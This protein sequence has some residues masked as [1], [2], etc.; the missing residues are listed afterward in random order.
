M[1]HSMYFCIICVVF[2][3]LFF[4]LLVLCAH[5]KQSHT[6]FN[7]VYIYSSI[8]VSGTVISHGYC[9][10]ILASPGHFDQIRPFWF[11]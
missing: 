5:I 8:Y 1:P 6:D 11:H 10:F 7:K 4:C 2:L 3:C 9:L